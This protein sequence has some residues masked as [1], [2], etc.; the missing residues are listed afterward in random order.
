M[1]HIRELQPGEQVPMEL[2]LLADPD[3]AIIASYLDRSRVF[4]LEDSEDRGN[5]IGSYLLLP[6]RPHT[7]ELVNVAVR[8][9]EQGK[10]YGRRLVKHAINEARESGFLTMEVGTGNSSIGQL[11][12]YQKC[13]FEISGIDKGFFLRHYKEPIFED[14]IECKDMVRLKQEL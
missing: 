11:A 3:T 4:I 1:E 2:L 6:T 7:V 14:G 13:G 5:I 8:E 9:S 12:L 10:G